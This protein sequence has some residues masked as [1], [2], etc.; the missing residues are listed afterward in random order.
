MLCGVLFAVASPFSARR[1]DYE[2]FKSFPRLF[3]LYS[4]REPQDGGCV[5]EATGVTYGRRSNGCSKKSLILHIFQLSH[6]CFGWLSKIPV[7]N[8]QYLNRCNKNISFP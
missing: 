7:G 8:R 3:V 5:E 4:V 2:P 1:K 6:S